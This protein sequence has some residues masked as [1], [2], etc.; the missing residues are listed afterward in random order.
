MAEDR[1]TIDETTLLNDY[2]ARVVEFD[3]EASGETY[4]FAVQYDVLEALSGDVPEDDEAAL[5]VVRHGDDIATYAA[6]ALARDPDQELIVISESD[7]E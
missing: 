2:D 7:M 4:R 5:L 1:V 3:G 6:A